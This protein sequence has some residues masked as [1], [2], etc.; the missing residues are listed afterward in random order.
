M[1]FVLVLFWVLLND[2][3]NLKAQNI[4]DVL[5]Q[6]QFFYNQTHTL[7]AEFIQ[8]TWF[9]SGKIETSK[10]KLW[11]KKPGKLRW[12][13][14]SPERFI[15][16]SDGK[17]FYISYP[18][19]KQ[20]FKYSS[21][22]YTSSQLVLGFMSGVGNIKKDLKLESFKVLEKGF[23][24]VTFIPNYQDNLNLNKIILITKPTT[25]EIKQIQL[26]YHTGERVKINFIKLKY[27]LNLSDSLFYLK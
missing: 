6:I 24:E 25:G 17:D 11:I 26:F 7:K 16:T 14:L 19:E 18:E 22:E 9:P 23:W 10:G 1:V 2:S 12:E 20:T 4:N 8:E 3:L 13:Y 5:N 21:R 15:I 27:N